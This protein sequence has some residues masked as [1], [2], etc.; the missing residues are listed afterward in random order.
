[1]KRLLIGLAALLL[2]ACTTPTGDDG[3]SPGMAYLTYIN[4]VELDLDVIEL[5]Y[6]PAEGDGSWPSGNLLSDYGPLAPDEEFRVE[7]ELGTYD[8]RA[9]DETDTAYIF[10]DA[11]ITKDGYTWEITWRDRVN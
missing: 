9:V 7:V 2:L 4:G 6:R 3:P 10:W 11:V 5:Y 1:M 8:L